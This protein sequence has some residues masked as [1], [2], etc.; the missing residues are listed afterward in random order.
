MLSARTE[1]ILYEPHQ[2]P[3]RSELWSHDYFG[4]PTPDGSSFIGYSNFSHMWAAFPEPHPIDRNWVAGR[5]GTIVAAQFS[6]VEMEWIVD[7][8]TYDEFRKMLEGEERVQ[9]GVLLTVS[10]NGGICL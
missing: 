8:D 10:A 2:A 7:L 1:V 5:G 4:G 9:Q 6:P 3:E